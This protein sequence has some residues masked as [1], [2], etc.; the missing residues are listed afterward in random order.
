VRFLLL[1]F[2]QRELLFGS[3]ILIHLMTTASCYV[4]AIGLQANLTLSDALVFFPPVILLTAVPISISGWGVREGAM[5]ACLALAG[6]S[7]AKA[8]A[9]SLLMGVISV[10]IGIAGGIVWLVSP[11][12]SKFTAAQAVALAEGA[13]GPLLDGGL[14]QASE[15]QSRP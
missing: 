13:S 11:E 3:A 5:V 6:V 9:I 2:K 12:R 7:P 14:E 15:M 8:L 1:Q 10:I 4:L